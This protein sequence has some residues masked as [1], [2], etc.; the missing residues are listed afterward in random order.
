MNTQ[1]IY[2][3]IGVLVLGYFLSTRGKRFYESEMDIKKKI[4]LLSIG[5]VS[6]VA[7]NLLTDLLVKKNKLLVSLV[8]MILVA[9]LV[10][11]NSKQSEDQSVLSAGLTMGTFVY[12]VGMVFLFGILM[13]K[14]RALKKLLKKVPQ[15]TTLFLAL[16]SAFVLN[17]VY[18]Q[19]GIWLGAKIR[20]A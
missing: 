2:N 4:S 8:L 11:Y 9:V 16:V 19:S 14:N 10:G 7:I 1:V 15:K 3:L 6:P 13:T 5:M 12:Q 20:D 18:N 17:S